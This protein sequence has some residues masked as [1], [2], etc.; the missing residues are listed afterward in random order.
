M[1]ER[2]DFAC[3]RRAFRCSPEVRA[4]DL[5]K[6]IL[7]D[8]RRI[9]R[10]RKN[11]ENGWLNVDQRTRPIA[12][13]E[14]TSLPTRTAGLRRLAAYLP[15]VKRYASE[16]NLDRAGHA[17]VS[18]LSPYLKHRLVLES[19]VVA[20]VLAQ[21]RAGD[22]DKFLQEVLWRT[23][24]KGYLEWHPSVWVEYL[25]ALERERAQPWRANAKAGS[26]R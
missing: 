7:F 18:L 19:E 24:W 17:N 5:S 2:R 20:A 1:D 13:Q 23:Y 3:G 9:R 25:S 12:H 10:E 6:R 4:V 22:V 26:P 8:G 16:R 21:Y 11:E 14:T 15:Q